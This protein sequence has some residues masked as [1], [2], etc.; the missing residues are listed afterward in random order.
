MRSTRWSWVSLVGLAVGAMWLA[1]LPMPGCSSL[2]TGSSAKP[3]RALPGPTVALWVTRWDYRSAGDVDR[4]IA[5]AAA[6]GATDLL[7]Q[8]R[9]QGDAFYP[10]D[11]EPWGQELL[12]DLPAGTGDP[13]FDPL[14][15]AVQRAHDS[16]LRIHAWLNVMPLWKGPTPP[17]A[18]THPWTLHPEWR[19]RD[20]R[21]HP[22]PLGESYVIAN[23]ALESVQDHIVAVCR[24]LTDRYQLDGLHLDYVRFIPPTGDQAGR[25][26]RDTRT[27]SLFRRSTGRVSVQLHEDDAAFRSWMRDRITHLV[28]RIRTEAIDPH[29]GMTLTAAVWRRPDIARETYLQDAVAWLDAGTIDAA[30]PMIYTDDDGR[31]EQDL[32]AW[33]QA[34]PGARIMPG[35]GVYKHRPSQTPTQIAAVAGSDG[36]ALFGYASIFESVNPGQ[37]QSPAEISVRAARRRALA[38][39]LASMRAIAIGQ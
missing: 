23:P 36:F 1:L 18:S 29:P 12:A 16:G 10:S 24:D 35:I 17:R 9:G 25:Y 13:G 39:T 32:H 7:W 8:V 22:Q 11:L 26:P 2:P 21:G 6:L 28:G 30:M 4:I 15:R 38:D 14:A 37:D 31:F 33:R 19:L 34:A 20:E 3:R 5:D 27:M